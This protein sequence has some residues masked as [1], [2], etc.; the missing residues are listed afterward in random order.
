[1]KKIISIFL[2]LAMLLSCA[3]LVSCDTKK[4]GDASSE[5][6]F[7][8]KFFYHDEN[9]IISATEENTTMLGRTVKT[10][11]RYYDAETKVTTK[12]EDVLCFNWPAS[13][14]EVTFIGTGLEVEL[15][16]K[17]GRSEMKTS[18][19][20]CTSSSTARITPTSAR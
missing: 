19:S 3:A 9:G 16:S 6:P 13:G 5:E 15:C 7:V 4:T 10:L 2:S 12:R 18:I 17:P 14:F 8:E 20:L 1:M 11:Y